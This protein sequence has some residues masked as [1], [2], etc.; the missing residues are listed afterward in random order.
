PGDSFDVLG[1]LGRPFDPPAEGERI[2][3]VG[4]GVGVAPIALYAARFGHRATLRAIVGFRSRAYVCGI[5]PFHDGSIPLTVT[6]EDGSTG[7]EGRVVDGLA[8]EVCRHGID[9]ILV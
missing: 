2:L 9:R 7:Q 3:L 6:T 4:G 5:E 1:P 8:D